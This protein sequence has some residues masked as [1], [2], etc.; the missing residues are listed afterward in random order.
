MV[1]TKAK[2]SIYLL[3]LLAYVFGA[4][5]SI[6]ELIRSNSDDKIEDAPIPEILCSKRNKCNF[7]FKH[8]NCRWEE[9]CCD[10]HISDC[11]IHSKKHSKKG[12]NQRAREKR[13]VCI[14]QIQELILEKDLD[15]QHFSQLESLLASVVKL[16]IGSASFHEDLNN[17]EMQFHIIRET[18][19]FFKTID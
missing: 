9:N 2:S 3:G 1:F 7:F 13:R 18:Y 6:S 4:D 17:I 5:I 10:C 12:K 15:S 16:E 8:G 11:A 19:D 14:A